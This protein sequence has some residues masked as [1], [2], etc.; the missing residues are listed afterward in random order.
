MEG[1][2]KTQIKF[3][4]MRNTVFGINSQIDTAGEKINELEDNN[5]NCPK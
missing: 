4:E 3:L 2:K 1:I 5:R